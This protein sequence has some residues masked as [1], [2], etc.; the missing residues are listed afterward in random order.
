MMS[1]LTQE[2]LAVNDREVARLLGLSRSTVRSLVKA[3]QIRAVRAGRRL[4]IPLKQ[5]CNNPAVLTYDWMKTGPGHHTLP[6][7]FH[8]LNSGRS[9]TSWSA[10]ITG[11]STIRFCA[12]RSCKRHQQ[13]GLLPVSSAHAQ[14]ADETSFRR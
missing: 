1:N 4:F 13:D 10:R 12:V 8:V 3:G 11:S 2:P 5:M 7:H 9:S 6:P 14:K